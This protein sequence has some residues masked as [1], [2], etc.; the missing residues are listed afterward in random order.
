MLAGL[1]VELLSSI[2]SYGYRS[3]LFNLRLT[4]RLLYTSLSDDFNREFFRKR[5]HHYTTRS[6]ERLL[7]VSQVARLR[8][9]IQQLTIVAVEPLHRDADALQKLLRV[10]KRAESLVRQ[11]RLHRST[12]SKPPTVEDIDRFSSDWLALQESI[13]RECASLLREAL[14]NLLRAQQPATLLLRYTLA[15]WDGY[16]FKFASPGTLAQFVG[17]DVLHFASGAPVPTLAPILSLSSEIEYPI[18]GIDLGPGSRSHSWPIWAFEPLMEVSPSALAHLSRLTIALTMASANVDEIQDEGL[19]Y[20][21]SLSS[22]FAKLNITFLP[23][24]RCFLTFDYMSAWAHCISDAPLTS[25]SITNGYM[26]AGGLGKL[27]ESHSETLKSLQ[28]YYVSFGENDDSF[29]VF[30]RLSNFPM[31]VI[32]DLIGLTQRSMDIAIDMENL[33]SVFSARGRTAVK[34]LWQKFMG[35]YCV[36]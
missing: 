20:M 19:R 28:L 8:D 25:L 1:P 18:S 29:A 26:S 13:N 5:T 4:S 6:L 10:K 30:E 14:I 34:E 36:E 22:L 27:L 21:L 15:Q 31:L 17:A 32:L 33:G 35:C 2:T 11:N 24:E 23:G 9:S 3:D 12:S 7:K 16:G